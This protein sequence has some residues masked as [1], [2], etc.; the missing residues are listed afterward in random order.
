MPDFFVLNNIVFWFDLNICVRKETYLN[1]GC[2][3]N[4]KLNLTIVIFILFMYLYQVYYVSGG[5][6]SL[7]ISFS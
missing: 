1:W 7:E 4:F 3:L 6:L 5:I 2:C